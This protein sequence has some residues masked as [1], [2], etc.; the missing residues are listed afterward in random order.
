MWLTTA[1]SVIANA[2]CWHACCGRRLRCCPGTCQLQCGVLTDH[3]VTAQRLWRL[4][5]KT[6]D[7]IRGATSR[8]FPFGM[9]LIAAYLQHALAK[10]RMWADW[11]M[12]CGCHGTLIC[13]AIGKDRSMGPQVTVGATPPL[14]STG[15]GAH[16][17]HGGAS[18]YQWSSIV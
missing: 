5:M 16:P 15:C 8:S 3:T 2:L 11:L 17:C 14:L 18:L 6:S 4:R 7:K 13:V 9:P 10:W 1:V 12:S